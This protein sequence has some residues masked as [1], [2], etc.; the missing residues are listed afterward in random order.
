MLSQTI[1]YAL[2]AMTYLA[3]L[4]RG[5]AV[6]SETIAQQTRVPK[7]YLSKVL[8]DLV[9]AELVL[10]RRGP[11]GGFSLARDPRRVS[12]LDVVNAV[13]PIPRLTKCPLGNPAHVTLCPLHRRLDDA[14]A[15]IERE[16]ARTSLAEVRDSNARS[17]RPGRTYV[18]PTVGRTAA[19]HHRA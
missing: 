12:M 16:F 2:R 8:R 14:I 7:G 11:H 15:M 6:N 3:S 1:E 10:S 9:V 13:D 17:G 5:S 19:R 4:D 18:R